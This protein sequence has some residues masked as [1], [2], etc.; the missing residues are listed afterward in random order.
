MKKGKKWKK[1]EPDSSCYKCV[2]SSLADHW[3]KKKFLK[4]KIF[5]LNIAF[6]LCCLRQ[7]FLIVC[8][9]FKLRKEKLAGNMYQKCQKIILKKYKNT[10]WK[11]VVQ[12]SFYS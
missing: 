6:V 7:I 2:A 1:D 8:G 10:T 4:K 3:S 5:W 9:K 11:T 12:S